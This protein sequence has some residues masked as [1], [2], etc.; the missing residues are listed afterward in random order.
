LITHL[1]LS[2]WVDDRIGDH[3]GVVDT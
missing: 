2:D 1:F 3:L